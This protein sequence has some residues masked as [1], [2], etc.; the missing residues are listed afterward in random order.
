[1]VNLSILGSNAAGLK[2]KLES[3]YNTLNKF[4]PSICTIQETKNNKIGLIKLPG[5]QVFEKIRQNRGGGGLLTCV[6]VDL[7]PVLVS[8]CKDGAEILTVEISIENKKIRIIN[9]YGPQEDDEI[10]EILAFWQEL[11]GEIIRAKDEGCLIIVEMDANAKLGKD[12][13]S[14][15]THNISNNGKLLLDIIE[16]QDLVIGNALDICKGVVTRERVFENKIERS[17]IDYI[18]MCGELA[19]YTKEMEIDQDRIHTLA[20]YVKN[21]TGKKVIKSDHNILFCKFS[22]I[23]NRKSN[24][25]RNEHFIFKCNES[26]KA[27]FDETNSTKLLTS[28][29]KDQQDFLKSSKS[30]FKNLNR[31]F[32]KCFKKIRI[33]NGPRKTYGNEIIQEKMDL[34]TKLKTFLLNNKCKVAQEVAKKKLNEIEEILIEQMA[35]KN[36]TIVKEHLEQIEDTNGGFS[37]I[38]FWKLKQKLHPAAVDP[39]LAKKDKAG[40]LVT[41]PEAIKNLYIEEYISRLKNRDMKPELLDLYF[42]KTELWM[43]RLNYLKNV[44]SAP[45]KI[46]NLEKVLKGL[47]N[48][49]CMDPVG[50]INEIFKEGCIGHDLKEALL[51]LFNGIKENQVIPPI[52][53]LSNI[54]TIFKNKGSRLELDNDRGIFILTVMKKILDKLIYVDKYDDIDKNMTDSNIGARKNRNIKDHLL[55]IHGIINSVVRGNEDCIDVQIYDL[56]KAFDALWLEDVLNDAFDSLEEKSRDDKI[57]LLYEANRNNLVA[58][59][60]GVGLTKRVNIPNIVQQG[61]TWGPLSC[62]NSIDT[63]GKKCKTRN[64]HFYMYKK[65]IKIFPLAFIDDLNG[66]AKC[67]PDS[68]ELNTYLNTQIE[69]KKLR[70]HTNRKNGK[71][72]CVKIHIGKHNNTCPALKVHGTSMNEVS[73][74]QY[75]GDIIS[76]DGKNSKNIKNRISKGVGLISQ[77]MNI[78][79]TASFGPFY[80]EIAM[81]LRE[82]ILVNGVTTNTE[83]WHNISESEIAEF[84]NLDKL[85]FQRLLSVPKSTPTESFFLELGAIPMGIIIKSRRV[86]YLHS[87]LNRSPSSMLYKFFVTQC[88]FPCKGDWS[89]IVRRDLEDLE[90]QESFEQIKNK[91]RGV[92]KNLV[93]KKTREF[94]LR[95]LQNSQSKHSKMNNLQYENIEIQDYFLR[96]D[97]NNE[98]KKLIFKFRTRMA[99]FGENF[100][101]GRSQVNCPLCKTHPDK[102]ELSYICPF[103]NSKMEV[104]GDMNEIY[105]NNINKNTIETIEKITNLRI[106]ILENNVTLPLQAQVPQGV[107]ETG[108]LCAAQDIVCLENL[109]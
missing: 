12:V 49:K 51:M 20:R 71:S 94:A 62:S 14:E 79:E 50:M 97:I 3:F 73:E 38:G 91:S 43:S 40:N 87:I 89:E 69:M 23:F 22:I 81:L 68:K 9:G 74:E 35:N 21:K 29:F 83:V 93:K 67:G 65:R 90:I 75:L 31:I 13:I 45:W 56:E 72:K 46:E 16:R 80:F 77:I 53:T 15:D 39:P 58:V 103:I 5:Y 17:A 102:Q 88:N 85:F 109:D 105:G 10:Q 30:F 64:Q 70:F 44:K 86:K 52:M 36:A 100:K 99:N 25:V 63:I 37:N 8:S 54:S 48:N 28:S 26:K 95:R 61:G 6:D 55:I 18:L 92:F 2:S 60:T 34:K 76:S 7:N 1:M 42:L 19:K 33:R 101:G 66:I 78:L 32:Q 59:K 84:E 27:F 98:Q 108:K 57:S 41:S 96:K 104:E 4:R 47:K 11:E 106:E 24:Q 82:A 107:Q